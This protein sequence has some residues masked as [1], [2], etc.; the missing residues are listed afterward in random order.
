M[1]TT[2][3][4][5]S[6][7]TTS[8]RTHSK[9]RGDTSDQIP[10]Y[11]R[12]IAPKTDRG[13]WRNTLD[14]EISVTWGE[15]GQLIKSWLMF[16]CF[17]RDINLSTRPT[18]R[19][20]GGKMK[21]KKS[22]NPLPQVSVTFC[23]LKRSESESVNVLMAGRV[24]ILRGAADLEA[25]DTRSIFFP[26]NHSLRRVFTLSQNWES[27][28]KQNWNDNSYVCLSLILKYPLAF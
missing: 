9:Q 1:N 20:M 28:Y 27:T 17:W 12:H 23:R 13:W 22:R 15:K 14:G 10:M 21:G 24:E 26:P 18:S 25:E 8:E 4:S 5:W 16:R 6:R 7:T 19:G 2:K 11:S 3:F